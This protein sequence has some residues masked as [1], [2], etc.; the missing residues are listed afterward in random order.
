MKMRGLPLACLVLGL[1]TTLP[2]AAGLERQ[3]IDVSQA[4]LGN[5]VHN[6]ELITS[7]GERVELDDYIGKPLAISLIFTACV[8]AC[9]VT[10]RHISRVV[11]IARNA[12]GDDSFHF[13]TIGFDYPVDSPA[14]MAQYARR[15][16]AGDRHWEFLTTDDAEGLQQLMTDLG[17][18]V[19]PSPR[20]YDHTVQ[21]TIVDPDGRVYRQVYG[22]LFDTPLLVEPMKDLTLGR[23]SPDD[24]LLTRVGNRVRL[25]C[26]V[27]D[28][29]ADR[30]YFDYSLFIGIF[31]G[32]VFLG[33]ATIWLGLEIVNRRK[34]AA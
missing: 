31:I 10:T 19:E 30:Y 15:H 20:G 12:L 9:S 16:G 28:A 33:W 34:L 23:P 26:T 21:L 14:A 2:V 11:Q 8:H 25:F 13:L 7:S 32:A 3:A 5:R 17:F 22:E 6:L 27:Y 29:K 18:M 1:L 4:A 24:G